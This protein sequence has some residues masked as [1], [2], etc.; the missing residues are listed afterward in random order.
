M[1]TY[2]HKFDTGSFIKISNNR[3]LKLEKLGYCSYVDNYKNYNDSEMIYTEYDEYG[4]L[5]R[6]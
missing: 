6:K 3:Y 4:F 2:R 5:I 1:K